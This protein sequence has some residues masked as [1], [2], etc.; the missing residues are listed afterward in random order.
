M[1]KL[2]IL[3]VFI[4]SFFIFNFLAGCSYTKMASRSETIHYPWQQFVMGADLSYVNEIEDTG[5]K[6]YSESK[7]VDPFLIF[8]DNGCNNVRVRLWHN[9]TWKKDVTGGKMY[10]DLADAEKSIRRAKQA[11]MSVNLNLHYSD[12]WADPNK[13]AI[14][15]AWEGLSLDVLKDSVYNYTLSILNYLHVKNLVPEMIQIGNENNNGMLW[16]VG[17]VEW[18]M[19]ENWN[20]FGDLIN[21]G[22]RAVRDFSK[23]SRIKP[24][25]IIHVAQLQYAHQWTENITKLGGVNDY[26]ILGLSHYYKWSTVHSMKDVGDTIQLLVNKYGKKVMV[27]ETAFP[28]TFE[29]SDS[30][31]NLFGDAKELIGYEA[32][33]PAQLEYMKNL[34]QT[35]IS[36]GGDGIMY[37][38]PAWITSPMKDRWGSGSSWE[39][40]ALF[41]FKGNVLPA[42]KF[43]GLQYKF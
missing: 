1:K 25:V 7:A 39:N 16:P 38:E 24:Q 22:I 6:Y 27:V 17:K 15:A 41:D 23:T 8:S 37:W 5:G 20:N 33:I 40:A 29:N 18:N 19:P 30:Y 36:A 31:N 28:W 35:I 10:S 26:D 13:Q 9:P 4:F 11:G 43:M 12:D 14:P 34:T 21:S 42:I 3:T 2:F 32:S